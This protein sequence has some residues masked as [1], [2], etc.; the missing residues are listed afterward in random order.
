MDDNNE[1]EESISIKVTMVGSVGVGKSCIV[2]RYTRNIF[3]PSS[4]STVGASYFK[5]ELVVNKKNVLLDIW[6]TAGQEKFHSMGRHFYKNSNIVVIVYDMTNKQTFEDIKNYWYNDVKE[7]GEIYKVIG[8]VGNK[9]DLYDNEGIKEIDENMIKD[10]IEQISVDKDSKFVDM[11]VSAKTGVNIKNLFDKL[12][13]EYLQKEFKFLVKQETIKRGTTF[14]MMENI[15]EEKRG[16][17][18]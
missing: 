12:V 7:N 14:K 3:S 1:E 16:C 10:F 4:K 5:K 6:D 8:I 17:C 9:M 15:K 11:K 2:D 18:K 13:Q